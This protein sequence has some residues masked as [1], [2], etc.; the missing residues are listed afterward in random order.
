M[1]RRCQGEGREVPEI[2]ALYAA[3]YG[4]GKT[5]K[6][7][8][9]YVRATKETSTGTYGYLGPGEDDRNMQQLYPNWEASV[10]LYNPPGTTIVDGFFK[11]ADG[12]LGAQA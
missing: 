10:T 3:L 12:P 8:S 4:S 1:I 9:S 2:I 7:I 6:A 11:I 5:A